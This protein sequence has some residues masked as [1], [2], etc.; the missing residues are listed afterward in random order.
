MIRFKNLGLKVDQA[1]FERVVARA[2][3]FKSTE[4]IVQEI[5]FAGY[6]ANIVTY[7]M[8]YLSYRTGRRIDLARIWREQSIST[9]L[10]GAIRMVAP[11]VQQVIISTGD[12]KNITEWC[13][14]E[15]CWKAIQHLAVGIPDDLL[16]ELSGTGRQL[17]GTATS[18]GVTLSDDDFAAVARVRE[19]P[20]AVWMDIAS[21]AKETG[22]LLP[23]Q[24]GLAFSLGKLA[25]RGRAPSIKQANQGFRILREAVNLG[26]K[27]DADQ[28]G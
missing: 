27:L 7:T 14:K 3:L 5:K 19:V 20:G 16:A 9:A 25:D 13:K 15:E 24:R 28:G 17:D 10:E 23:W 1:Y 2:I 22:H 4:S 6:R 21:W 18:S 11:A 26:Y 12:G 8:A